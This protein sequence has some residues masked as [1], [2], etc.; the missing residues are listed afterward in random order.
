MSNFQTIDA[1]ALDSVTGGKA[2]SSS[3]DLTSQLTGLQ[4]SIADLAKNNTQNKGLFGNPTNA[5]M[6]AMVAMRN[7]DQQ[8]QGVVVVR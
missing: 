7:R 5:M 4:S 6:F 2:T 8:N 3:A 1:L